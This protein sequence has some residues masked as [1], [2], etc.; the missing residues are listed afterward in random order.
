MLSTIKGKLTYTEYFNEEGF[1][2][3]RKSYS[4]HYNNLLKSLPM[5]LWTHSPHQPLLRFTFS[6]E[7]L[8]YDDVCV[9]AVFCRP[10]PMLSNQR[11]Q[12]EKDYNNVLQNFRL[13]CYKYDI[14][15]ENKAW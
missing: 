13:S 4:F 2:V 14:M 5:E 9:G 12:P 1:T 8:I 7:T 10:L 6:T 15:F 11:C 3:K